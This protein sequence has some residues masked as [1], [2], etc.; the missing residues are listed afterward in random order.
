MTVLASNLILSKLSDADILSMSA[1]TMSQLPGIAFTKTC[2]SIYIG[3]NS[4]SSHLYGLKNPQ[5]IIGLNDYELKSSV[6]E[7]ADDFRNEDKKIFNH[8]KIYISLHI[9]NYLA[10]KRHVF[11]TQ[12]IPVKNFHGNV[13]GLNCVANE[14]INPCATNTI[15]NL[16]RSNKFFINYR[17][18]KFNL[19]VDDGSLFY[20][21][22]A[23]E[24]EV[25][26]LF[27]I[28]FSQKD[29]G[30]IENTS[31]RQIIECLEFIRFKLKCSYQ[32]LTNLCL[33]KHYHKIIPK[34]LLDKI[35]SRLMLPNKKLDP[36]PLSETRCNESIQYQFKDKQ[37]NSFLTLTRQ[38]SQCLY[39]LLQGKG[40]KE[41]ARELQLS[42]RTVEHY[43]TDIRR[44]NGYAST[45]QLLVNVHFD[46]SA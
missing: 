42:N 28:G 33:K 19:E 23:F 25:L 34:S 44:K 43:V 1:Q 12:K 2:E 11:L 36:M 45:K 24:N 16:L 4:Y 37:R 17:K 41:I 20:E 31:L 18:E 6:V 32:E 29:I 26:Y 21:L 35:F 13:I 15:M 7:S 9:N 22:N 3:A 10:G 39:Y 38:Q 27:N 30:Y 46:P 14:I 5:Q 8:G 40:A